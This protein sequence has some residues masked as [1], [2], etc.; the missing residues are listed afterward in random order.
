MLTAAGREK[1]GWIDRKSLQKFPSTDLCTIDQLWVKYSRKRFGFSVQKHIWESFINNPNAPKE[2]SG[3][4]RTS[5]KIARFGQ[6]LGLH[7][8]GNWLKINELT[9]DLSAPVG[10]L[11]SMLFAVPCGDGEPVI[12]RWCTACCVGE[13]FCGTLWAWGISDFAPKLINCDVTMDTEMT[14]EG[15]GHQKW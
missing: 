4:Q 7:V 2:T 3:K 1:E 11:P 14:G 8:N 12:G 6:L 9:F 15:I 13:L 5:E 10:H